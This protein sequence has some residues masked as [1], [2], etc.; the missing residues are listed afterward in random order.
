MSDYILCTVSGSPAP[1]PT[2]GLALVTDETGTAIGPIP[3]FCELPE[4]G[5]L[6]WVEK[7]GSRKQ[8]WVV[9]DIQTPT[10]IRRTFSRY[11][12]AR[13]A[14]G[15]AGLATTHIGTPP[16]TPWSTGA[17]TTTVTT[18]TFTSDCHVDIFAT[19][20][21]GQFAIV[22]NFV[23]ATATGT[24]TEGP[25]TSGGGVYNQA[26][27]YSGLALSGET[28]D[29]SV[30]NASAS[31]SDLHVKAWMTFCDAHWVVAQT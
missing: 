27:R 30:R 20:F 13:T 14:L 26:M 11:A 18:V 29:F 17:N 12:W 8:D 28:F 24:V 10:S 21:S 4:A 31:A 15:I 3:V 16:T 25:N 7:R 19:V 6:V 9:T 23:T 1:D 5:W 22:S 2:T